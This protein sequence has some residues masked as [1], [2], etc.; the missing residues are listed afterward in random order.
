M[1][2]SETITRKSASNLALAFVLLPK[3]KRQGM[4]ALYAFCRE[5]DDIADN[6]S[7][8]VKQRRENLNAWRSDIQAACGGLRPRF[9]VT[10]ELA[11]ILPSHNLTYG[12][13][14]ELIRGV[15]MDLDRNRYESFSELETYCYRVASVVGLLSIEILG[16]QNVKTKDYAIY[17]GKA[18]Q[19]TNILRDVR[20]DAEMGRIYIPMEQLSEFG[21]DTQDILTG[22][23]SPEFHNCANWLASRA[24]D[25]YNQAKLSLPEVDRHSM[26]TSELMGAVYWKIL[27]KIEA[28]EF[29]VFDRPLIKLSKA[30]KI[31]LIAQMWLRQILGLPQG[32]YGTV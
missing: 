30:Q 15:E 4:C 28:K 7:V 9:P 32:M 6:E 18:L 11:T 8:P 20:K 14:D 23:Y 12:L 27:R 2:I 31:G 5:V 10:K 19:L 13:F 22:K 25:F 16:Y 3:A 21:V 17:L 24:R 29:N 1:Q 26:R